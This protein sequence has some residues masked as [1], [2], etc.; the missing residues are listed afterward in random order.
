VLVATG[1]LVERY[2]VNC[3]QAL[4][5]LRKQARTEGRKVEE[6]AIALVEATEKLNATGSFASLAKPPGSY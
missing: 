5:I 1:I 2:H 4:E 6:A 3:D